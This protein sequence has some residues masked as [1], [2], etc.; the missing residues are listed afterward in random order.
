MAMRAGG[1]AALLCTSV[2]AA[3]SLISY[4]RVVSA[5]WDHERRQRIE[6]EETMRERAEF[7][8]LTADA[9]SVPDYCNTEELV[10]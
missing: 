10:A 4:A 8:P 1:A 6:D 2:L 9:M 5:Q 3:F 7:I